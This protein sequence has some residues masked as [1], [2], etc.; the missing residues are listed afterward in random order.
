LPEKGAEVRLFFVRHGVAEPWETWPGDDRARPLTAAGRRAM[1]RAA[2]TF[3]RLGLEPDIIVSSPLTRARETAAIVA[4]GLVMEDRVRVDGRLAPGF[5]VEQLEAIL[6]ES[7]A[8]EAIM[9]VG[10]EPDLSAL[11]GDLVGGGAVVCR[12]GGLARVDVERESRRGKLVWLLPPKVL[13]VSTNKGASGG[14]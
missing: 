3:A 10:H 14:D 9:F 8:A 4:T 1:V 5:G 2:A 13:S 6:E 11:I 7:P 12:K